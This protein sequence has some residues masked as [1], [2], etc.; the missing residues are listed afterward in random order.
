[1]CQGWISFHFCDHESHQ[2]FAQVYN[3]KVAYPGLW[4]R[5]HLL[6][7]KI[8]FQCWSRSIN[9]NFFTLSLRLRQLCP[10]LLFVLHNT[11]LKGGSLFQQCWN[12]ELQ[13]CYTTEKKEHWCLNKELQCYIHS[14]FTITVF[15]SSISKS[16]RGKTSWLQFLEH[17]GNKSNDRLRG[18]KLSWLE[19]HYRWSVVSR[20]IWGRRLWV[21]C[22]S[23]GLNPNYD[24]RPNENLTS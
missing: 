3:P 10:V 20:A 1:M 14:F 24:L 21:A 23:F 5:P 22:F 18:L 11:G 12:K 15:Y 2:I 6:L 9:L 17:C 4:L 19:M 13:W 7:S 8:S 16:L